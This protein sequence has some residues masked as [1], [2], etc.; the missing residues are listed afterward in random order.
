[1]LVA[2]ALDVLKETSTSEASTIRSFQ[3][4]LS[5]LLGTARIAPECMLQNILD[6]IDHFF[7]SAPT[8]SLQQLEPGDPYAT[9]L[10]TAPHLIPWLARSIDYVL[11]RASSSHTADKRMHAILSH[12]SPFLVQCM[13]S[14]RSLADSTATAIARVAERRPTALDAC[15]ACIL[16]SLT[17]PTSAAD[18]SHTSTPAAALLLPGMLTQHQ[19]DS[20][21][22]V[23]LNTPLA[24]H[25][26]LNLLTKA[27]SRTT[28]SG[29]ATAATHAVPAAVAVRAAHSAYMHAPSP[30]PLQL[31]AAA[32][33][34]LTM[35][36]STFDRSNESTWCATCGHCADALT[37]LALA[38]IGAAHTPAE[39]PLL[40]LL[41]TTLTHTHSIT[42]ASSESTQG[43]ALLS[44]A[45][46]VMHAV[47]LQLIHHISLPAP[48]SLK[49][50]SLSLLS[51]T[52]DLRSS[53]HSMHSSAAAPATPLKIDPPFATWQ[54]HTAAAMHAHTTR[55]GYKAI[56]TTV[57]FLES[58]TSAAV[59]GIP[60]E[61]RLER[62]QAL[63]SALA[64]GSLWPH[65][66]GSICP[67]D[68]IDPP[69]YAIKEMHV[70]MHFSKGYP[71]TGESS[72]FSPSPVLVA[73]IAAM[74]EHPV[75]CCALSAA[76]ALVATAFAAPA[77]VV[78]NFPGLLLTAQR[79]L[80]SLE[81]SNSERTPEDTIRLLLPLALIPGVCQAPE[82][83]GMFYALCA[84][85]LDS[86][87]GPSVCM[88]GMRM[89]LTFWLATGRGYQR[90]R[91]AMHVFQSPSPDAPV[92]TLAAARAPEDTSLRRA[93]AA[94]AAAV[95]WA[96]P[97][98]ATE[99]VAVMHGAM[100]DRDD[101]TVAM[102][103]EAVAAM[104][105]EVRVYLFL[106][107]A[108]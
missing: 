10:S 88:I 107:A 75:L 13:A 74:L 84:Q 102:A 59:Q 92:A 95:A 9:L 38:A 100:T 76:Q 56:I 17:L 99:L 42:T 94:C 6:S 77:A 62:C 26:V 7:L 97:E 5:V 91:D 47:R 24:T 104:C 93:V 73:H 66:P 70:P 14:D 45:W 106:H 40:H 28:H 83:D 79:A 4:T 15:T 43:K 3:Q 82:L 21:S 80:N 29:K 25:R 90:V 54:A 58:I 101:G 35:A 52:D 108:R 61:L 32:S 41:S 23:S 12:L 68:A 69:G 27:S 87:A 37:Q 30:P 48:K 72:S 98:K 46:T 36:V 64:T 20:A 11:L 49:R 86:S 60:D 55:R 1:M 81:K 63:V 51:Q 16:A 71:K 53:V 18:V 96:A 85:L 50:L 8:T 57:G 2:T 67:T 89:L 19:S 33:Q 31:S 22:S 105:R 34:L 78:Q 103:L 65:P 44:H 39:P